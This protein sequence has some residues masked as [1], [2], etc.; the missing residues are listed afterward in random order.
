MHPLTN[1]KWAGGYA[2]RPFEVH[3]TD[4]EFAFSRR[5]VARRAA[6]AAVTFHTT[7]TAE[8]RN[9]KN[10]EKSKTAA[11]NLA[12]AWTA[13]PT[14]TPTCLRGMGLEEATL[15][16]I[17]QGHRRRLSDSDSD[18]ARGASFASRR[19][20]WGLA[21]EIAAVAGTS[22]TATTATTIEIQHVLTGVG[23]SGVADADADASG[24]SV[25]ERE[26][27][28]YGEVKGCGL[29][30]PRRRVK[31]EVWTEA[32]KGWVRNEGDDGYSL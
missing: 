16:G 32:L 6:G 30:T 1:R 2:F 11:S 31:E 27:R 12:V 15:G 4:L 28:T 20:L 22:T 5:E 3:T 7:S 10:K 8:T 17:L 19:Q 23:G 14:P 9:N 21:A 24:A 29:L 18:D 13:A 25:E 26:K